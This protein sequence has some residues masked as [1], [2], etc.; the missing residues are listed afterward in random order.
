M[1]DVNK[2]S[3][4]FPAYREQMSA[5]WWQSHSSQFRPHTVEL[6]LKEIENKMMKVQTILEYA[7]MLGTFLNVYN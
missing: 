3:L 4:D 2:D 6:G 7:E 1:S 5:I